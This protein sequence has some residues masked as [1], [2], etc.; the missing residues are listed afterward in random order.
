MVARCTYVT[1]PAIVKL[2]VCQKGGWLMPFCLRCGYS[3]DSTNME[4]CEKPIEKIRTRAGKK[5]EKLSVKPPSRDSSPEES[6]CQSL[7]G[8][9]LEERERQVLADIAAIKL[10]NRVAELE[11]ER[12]RLLQ[13]RKQKGRPTFSSPLGQLSYE[14]DGRTVGMVAAGYAPRKAPLM[15][16]HDQQYI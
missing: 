11:A 5:A 4:A 12:E 10:E 3:H 13:A 14:E 8:M 9:T 16:R 2:D 7:S 6:I 1:P 15:T